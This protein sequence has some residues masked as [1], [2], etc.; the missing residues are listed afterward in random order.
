MKNMKN[1]T[2][3]GDATADH[4]SDDDWCTCFLSFGSAAEGIGTLVERIYFNEHAP[5]QRSVKLL[6]KSCLREQ[7]VSV[8]FN[9]AWIVA[10][11][12]EVLGMVA[13]R[14]LE[15]MLDRLAVEE[16][17]F[18]RSRK[19]DEVI[20]DLTRGPIP[21]ATLKCVWATIKEHASGKESKGPSSV[22]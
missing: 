2:N 15:L 21:R 8:V 19:I 13:R 10:P 14:S 7:F 11:R 1:M 17:S 16:S 3:I 5:Q 18:V 4:M 20:R 22:R 6:Q 12:D 9:N